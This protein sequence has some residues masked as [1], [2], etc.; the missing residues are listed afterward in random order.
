[1]EGRIRRVAVIGAGPSGAIATDALVKEQ[2]FDEVY[3]F[4]RHAVA[5][6]T[7]V[8]DPNSICGIPCLRDLVEKSA[9]LPKVIVIGGSV[10][11]VEA[12]HEIRTVSKHPVIVSLRKP[13]YEFGWT[14]F[15]HPHIQV[16]SVI[17][18]VDADSKCVEFADGSVAQDVDLLL[19][20][21]GYDFSFPFLSGVGISNRRIRGLYQHVFSQRDP[22]LAFLGMVSGGLTFRVFEW[23]AV[24][25]ARVF[26]G[27][28]TL[29][30]A[31]A[32]EKWE[33]TTS[34]ANGD[35]LSFF[36]IGT[37]YEGYFESLRSLAGEPAR[38][39][40][41]RILPKYEKS[42]EEGL[43]QV[44]EARRLWWERE[45]RIAEANERAN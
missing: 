31:E 20:A 15:V 24:A 12:I 36:N 17:A 19:F 7:W 27:R 4:E 10:S 6:G 43:V 33:E 18:S 30:P 41:G 28:V 5:G 23:Q 25:V 39:T 44:I 21:T 22:T 2:A 45:R 26:A 1:M 29:P 13:L 32:M 3:V 16:R 14:P 35:G 40:T 34:D 9:D 38:G 11:A 37:D 42:W 8:Y